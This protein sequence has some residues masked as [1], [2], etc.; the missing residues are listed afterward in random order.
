MPFTFDDE[1]TSPPQ[2]M[3]SPVLC[4]RTR[5]RVADLGAKD[6]MHRFGGPLALEVRGASVANPPLHRVLTLSLADPL[7]GFEMKG[8]TEL[9]LV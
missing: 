7:V 3:K 6:G 9:P 1:H 8:V 4:V 2:Q 5:V